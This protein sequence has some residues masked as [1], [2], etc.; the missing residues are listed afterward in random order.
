[1]GLGLRDGFTTMPVSILSASRQRPGR[2]AINVA[3]CWAHYS[4]LPYALR[5]CTR[6]IQTKLKVE[7]K[8]ANT[9][10]CAGLAMTP[11][12]RVM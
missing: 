12:V 7:E 5:P 3:R 10:E 11:G 2:G 1:M 8:P 6:I 4:H 9:V